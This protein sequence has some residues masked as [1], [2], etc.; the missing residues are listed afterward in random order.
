MD[1]M[2]SIAH[3]SVHVADDFGRTPGSRLNHLDLRQS[4]LRS[5]MFRNA[6]TLLHLAAS[7][8]PILATRQKLVS[9]R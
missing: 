9:L 4:G 1:A 3:D 5:A 8:K 2:L 6:Y 7:Y